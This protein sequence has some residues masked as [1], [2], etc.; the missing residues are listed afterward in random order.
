MGATITTTDRNIEPISNRVRCLL[1]RFL[2]GTI[3]SVS[4][5]TASYGIWA[6]ERISFSG[7]QDMEKDGIQLFPY[8]D[9]FLIKLE[10]WFDARRPVPPGTIK[11]HGEVQCVR[12]TTYT[13]VIAASLC[14]LVCISPF[15]KRLFQK[16]R[17]RA[18]PNHCNLC[19]YDLTGNI[20]GVCP[21]CGQRIDQ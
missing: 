6:L 4:L 18:N 20:S 9:T 2:I 19:F 5:A 10:E 11:I 14:C 15:V 21:E 8:P 12:E 7:F 1:I 17:A 3:F 16:W 13:V